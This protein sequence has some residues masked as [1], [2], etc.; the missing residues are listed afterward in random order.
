V[1]R[2]RRRRRGALEHAL[3]GHAGEWSRKAAPSLA[4]SGAGEDSSSSSAANIKVS[5]LERRARAVGNAA[6]SSSPSLTMSG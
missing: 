6:P 4:D 1:A 3:H 2:P 5:S